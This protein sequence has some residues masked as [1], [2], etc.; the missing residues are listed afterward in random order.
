MLIPQ[1]KIDSYVFSTTQIISV[2]EKTIGLHLSLLD[3]SLERLW[4]TPYE[5]ID[6]EELKKLKET[7]AATIRYEK[8]LE[9]HKCRVEFETSKSKS[10]FKSF[11]LNFISNLSKYVKCNLDQIV[12]VIETILKVYKTYKGKFIYIKECILHSF[13]LS[14]IP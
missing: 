10:R 14:T 7:W 3:S 4:N 13:E 8:L 5:C 6:P 11:W 2:L 9:E 1:D 12:I